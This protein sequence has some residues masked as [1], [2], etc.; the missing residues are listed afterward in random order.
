MKKNQLGSYIHLDKKKKKGVAL[1]VKWC[2]C[3]ILKTVLL[4]RKCF[5]FPQKIINIKNC[6]LFF[7][8]SSELTTVSAHRI[9]TDVCQSRLLTLSKIYCKSN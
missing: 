2:D 7:F 1:S 9:D 8:F 6:D 3:F 5:F 4:K